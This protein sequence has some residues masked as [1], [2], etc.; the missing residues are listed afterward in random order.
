M[1]NVPEKTDSIAKL[2][3]PAYREPLV[4]I[5]RDAGF[6]DVN[7]PL[8]VNLHAH[9]LIASQPVTLQTSDGV[10]VA[11]ASDLARLGDRVEAS[12]WEATFMKWGNVVISWFLFLLVGIGLTLLAIK[13]WP[14]SISRALNLPPVEVPV[15]VQVKVPVPVQDERITTLDQIGARLE[16]QKANGKTYVYF[17]T[18]GP[19]PLAGSTRDGRNYLYFQP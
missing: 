6:T 7:D 5:I 9:A 13:L 12:I 14:E 3:K 17:D 4:R 10:T 2:V 18:G 15:E 1:N 11:T 16:V 8:L 19:E